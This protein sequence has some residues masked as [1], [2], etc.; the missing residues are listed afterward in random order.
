M[1]KVK[2][3]QETVFQYDGVVLFP[4]WNEIN[5]EDF[6]KLQTATLALELGILEFEAEKAEKPSKK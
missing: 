6:E 2:L 1:K 5:K 4:E 3:N